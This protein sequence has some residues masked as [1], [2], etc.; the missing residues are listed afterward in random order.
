MRYFVAT[1]AL[2][3]ASMPVPALAQHVGHGTSQPAEP[4]K[5][6]EPAVPA[7]PTEPAPQPEPDHSAMDHSQMSHPQ[8]SPAEHGGH[9][10]M[11][12]ALGPYPMAREASGTAW[13]PDA[14]E[15]GGIVTAPI[16]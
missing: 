11:T 14:S 2:A 10:A 7:K 6:A 16:R 13:Q 9:S 1:S 4:A 3:L 8:T 12:G 5:P 15:H